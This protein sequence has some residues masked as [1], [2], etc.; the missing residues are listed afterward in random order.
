MPARRYSTP[1]VADGDYS[2]TRV[3]A[4]FTDVIL[5]MYWILQGMHADVAVYAKTIP[6]S[7]TMC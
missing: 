6:H 7:V 4:A 2:G 5:T 1:L 3:L